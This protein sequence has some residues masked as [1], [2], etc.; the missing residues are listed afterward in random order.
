M[1]ALLGGGSEEELSAV[2][3]Y[4][5]NVG[6]AFISTTEIWLVAPILL[7]IGIVLATIS[8]VVTLKRYLKV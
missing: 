6:V 5:E 2:A 7:I 1:G 8:S 4:G 3:Q